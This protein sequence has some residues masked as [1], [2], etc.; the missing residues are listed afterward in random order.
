MNQSKLYNWLILK[1]T[2][3]LGEKSIKKL[4]LTFGTPERILEEEYESIERVIGG[5]KARSLKGGSLSF[6]PEK[7]VHLIQ[8][9]GIRWMTLEDEEYPTPLKNIED[10]PPIVFYRGSLRNLNLIGVVGTRKPDQYSISFTREVANDIVDLSFGVVSG[11]AKGIDYLSHKFCIEAGGYSV[12]VLG[13]GIL[14]APTFLKD[15][16]LKNG[17]LVSEF[18]PWETPDT[19][20]FPRR[21]RII[22][23]MSQALFIVE[24]GQSSGALITADYA[25]RQKRPVYA[26]IGIGKS[27]RWNGCAQL[28]NQGK[29][30]FFRS[31]K[32]V[33]SSSKP[34]AEDLDEL[35]SLLL[36]PKTFE[37]LLDLS[38]LSSQDLSQKLTLYELEGKVQR[39]GSYYRLL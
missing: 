20:T 34:P 9:E 36:N 39:V 29:A 23:G 15:L 5:E 31:V 25:C 37:E 16:I 33:L 2:K 14:K 13:M 35:L 19:F 11:G 18:L 22:S 27:E 4:Y 1:A 21:N 26:H 3:G 10:P 30:M 8:K 28:I 24:A 38:G 7:V 6:D 17:L 12:C 32:E